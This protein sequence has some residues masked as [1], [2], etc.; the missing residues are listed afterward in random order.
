VR[1]LVLGLGNPLLGD[2]SVG[3]RVAE[4]VSR[5]V[6]GRPAVEVDVEYNGGL[7]LMERLAGYERA[8]LVDAIC[9][10]HHPP[11]SVLRLGPEELDTCHSASAHDVSLGT[12][13][14]LAAAMGLPMPGDLRILAVEAE[15]IL[16][17]DACCTPAV[18]AAV[19]RA[20]AAVLAELGPGHSPGKEET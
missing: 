14:R 4:A 10:G 5:Q 18:A 2:D 3:L 7:R 9:T 17:F 20:A 6:A 16:E 11:G 15:R 12:A 13:L 19:P 8:I 1:T